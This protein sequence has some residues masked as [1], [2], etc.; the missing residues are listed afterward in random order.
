[1]N[2][3]DIVT[4]GIGADTI[5]LT[6]TVQA[7]DQVRFSPGDGSVSFP[8]GTWTVFDTVTAF[9]A[10][11][12]TVRVT[13]AGTAVVLNGVAAPQTAGV[14]FTNVASG[15]F[16]FNGAVG[17]AFMTG[18]TTTDLTNGFDVSVLGLGAVANETVGEQAYFAVVVGGQVGIYHFIVDTV[19]G[20][21]GQTEL[22]LVGVVN[23]TGTL[24]AA[25]LVFF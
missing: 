10:D 15:A 6:E 2:G 1:G 3:T 24:S 19:D 13:G 9:N 7:A 23:F 11:F 14:T 18:T 21:A 20:F 25:D 5:N 12:D 8:T 16:D 17:G 4:G 22:E